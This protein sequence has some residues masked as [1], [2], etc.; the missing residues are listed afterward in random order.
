MTKVIKIF[1]PKEKPF[2]WLSNNYRHFMQL[3]GKEWSTVTNYI[4][5]NILTTPM[6]IQ[7]VRLTKNTKDVKPTFHRLYQQEVDNVVKQ[8]VETALKVKFENKDL[9]E[10]LLAT[11]N[12]PIFYVSSNPLL[13]TGSKNDGQ[14]VYGKY[15]AQIRHILRV[16]FKEQKQK[17]AK[18]EKDQNI[19]ET[20]LAEMGLMNVIRKGND[21]K[22]YMNKTPTKII[23]M[24]GRID[25]EKLAPPRDTVLEMAHKKYLNKD[26][27]NAIEYPETLVPLIR[28]KEMRNLRLRKIKERKEIIFDMYADYLLEK[29]FPDLDADQYAKAKDQQLGQMGWQQKN[30]LE[31]RLYDLFENGMLSSRLSDAIDERLAYHYV[32][33]EEAVEEAE[34]A[35]INF[36][37]KPVAL[38]ESYVPEK[39]QPILVY[40]SDFAELGSNYR[41]YLV[42]SPIS[43]TGMLN[44]G[45]KNFPTV[46]HYI[47]ARLIAHIPSVKGGGGFGGMEKA[48]PQLLANPDGPVEG[49]QSFLSPDNA[50]LRYAQFRDI[51]YQTHLEKYAKKGM[52]KKFEDRIIQDILLMTGNAKLVY[53]DF[54]DPILG[55]G[56]KHDKGL[57]VVGKYLMTLRTKYADLRKGETLQ[58]L[59][60]VHISHILDKD[61]FMKEWLNM[62]VRDMCKVLTAMKNYLYAK[63]EID[64]KLN[65][66]FT[67]TVL[68]NIYQPCSHVFGAANLITAEVP[69]YFRLMVQRCPGFSKVTHETV[70]V[71][72]KRIAVII[73]YL[74]KHIK[75]SNIQNIRTV[76]G[77]IELLVTKGGQCVDIIPDDYDNC[78]VS[79]L[80]NLLRGIVEFN[81]KFA[82]NTEVTELDVK[83]A[84]SII[85][86]S[87]VSDEVKPVIPV[88]AGDDKPSGWIPDLDL[89]PEDGKEEG[90]GEDDGEEWNFPDDDDGEGEFDYGDEDDGEEFSPR[91]NMLISVLREIDEVRDPEAIALVIEGALET[92]KTYPMSKQVKSNRIN[93]FA[94]QRA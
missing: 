68:D 10:K 8:A 41:E 51:S 47:T 72:W 66:D 16:S 28:K 26:L 17:L 25:L 76:L 83:T 5:A 81:K 86:N 14:N 53:N 73:Y 61:S 4:Y 43:L 23:E 33:S 60:H 13:G 57:N 70:E 84:A 49:I 35:P 21:L 90:D 32:P 89:V 80:I 37:D 77:R 78:I 45:G 19:Y 29:H 36:E 87:D 6:F 22:E 1:D 9:A 63:D 44:I 39:G 7:E 34:R 11:G 59:H 18:S 54:S 94:T 82:Y 38:E 15:L 88:P 56:G 75:E 48:Y 30:D 12:S 20:Y 91:K 64:I 55:I 69:Q 85:L 3:D 62:R 42:F 67:T 2:G 65:A 46:T 24:L 31:I 74:I 27:L 79:A 71:M 40:P 58:Q 92:I 93:F 50:N 52:D